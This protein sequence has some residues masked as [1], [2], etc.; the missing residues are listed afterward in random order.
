MSKLEIVN[1][2]GNITDTNSE[3]IARIPIKFQWETL[4]GGRN[5]LVLGFLVYNFNDDNWTALM[6][7]SR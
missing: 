1:A 2:S 6:E 4:S 3:F 5:G 7:E